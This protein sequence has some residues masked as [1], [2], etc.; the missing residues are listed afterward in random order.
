[1]LYSM[2]AINKPEEKSFISIDKAGVVMACFKKAEQDDGFIL[3]LFEST[4]K[5]SRVRIKPSFGIKNAYEVNLIEKQKRRVDIGN[6]E[7]KPFEIKTIL[8]EV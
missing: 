8:I 2:G 6:L 4:G 7:F 3:R 5:K 1:V